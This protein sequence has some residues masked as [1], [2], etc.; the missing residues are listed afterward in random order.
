MWSAMLGGRLLPAHFFF[1]VFAL[2]KS[3]QEQDTCR[4]EAHFF[5]CFSCSFCSTEIFIQRKVYVNAGRCTNVGVHSI[6]DD[7]TLGNTLSA[8]TSIINDWWQMLWNSFTKMVIRHTAEAPPPMN[9]TCSSGAQRNPRQM[10]NE[11]LTTMTETEWNS[12]MR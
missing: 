1:F 4:A 9:S 10:I 5:M 3:T 8:D 11:S 6:H 2:P 12:T 7:G